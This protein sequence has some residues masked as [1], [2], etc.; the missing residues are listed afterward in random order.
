VDLLLVLLAEDDPSRWY[1]H[2]AP[3]LSSPV[4]PRANR[5]GLVFSGRRYREKGLWRCGLP[6]AATV[7]LPAVA[8]VCL[9]AA[10]PPDHPS[11]GR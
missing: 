10:W 9:P 8:T 11:S 7:C 3:K 6:A 2:P 5:A 1:L 4:R